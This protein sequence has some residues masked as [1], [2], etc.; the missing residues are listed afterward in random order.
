MISM[1]L[2]H[3][4]KHTT[5]AS[6][7]S[8]EESIRKFPKSSSRLFS[9][10][11]R[12][13]GLSSVTFNSARSKLRAAKVLSSINDHQHN[14]IRNSAEVEKRA[15]DAAN[16]ETRAKKRR[17]AL[18]VLNCEAEEFLFGETAAEDQEVELPPIAS[19]PRKR[20]RNESDVFHMN[21]LIY[22]IFY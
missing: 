10:N 20:W 4:E 8:H 11:G 19:P 12:T 2:R 6:Q 15:V 1:R 22:L 16:R 5:Q 13:N 17:S 14:F 9:V 7:N 3:E 18:W 21:T